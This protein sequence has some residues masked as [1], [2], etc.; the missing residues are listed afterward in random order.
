[1]IRCHLARLMGEHKMWI[2]DAVRETALVAT[3]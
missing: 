1:M 2:A 3:P